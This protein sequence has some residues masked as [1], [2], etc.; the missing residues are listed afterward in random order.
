MWPKHFRHLEAVN[1]AG[2]L[3]GIKAAARTGRWNERKAVATC[4]F[5]ASGVL[6][7][8]CSIDWATDRYIG[9]RRLRPTS[10]DFERTVEH[11][12]VENIIVEYRFRNGETPF[13]VIRFAN[14]LP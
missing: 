8:R 12:Y 1:S 7:A 3:V 9:A 10:M 2:V 4:G 5:S 13:V 14:P 6:T 11:G